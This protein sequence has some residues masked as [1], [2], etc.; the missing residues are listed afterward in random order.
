MDD[1]LIRWLIMQMCRNEVAVFAPWSALGCGFVAHTLSDTYKFATNGWIPLPNSSKI[2]YWL[3]EV[4]ATYD[5]WLPS[6]MWFQP[7]DAHF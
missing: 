2:W 1:Q 6:G 3:C 4:P 7:Q 5:K